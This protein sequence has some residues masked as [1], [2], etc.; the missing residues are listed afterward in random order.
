V[1]QPGSCERLV[2]RQQ[3]LCEDAHPLRR[4]SGG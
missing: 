2:D 4:V 3:S 1:G